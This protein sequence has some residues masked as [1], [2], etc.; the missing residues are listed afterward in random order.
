MFVTISIIIRIIYIVDSRKANS[1]VI[2]VTVKSLPMLITTF[3]I[4]LREVVLLL[5]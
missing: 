2:T 3:Q 1:N 5:L 4:F